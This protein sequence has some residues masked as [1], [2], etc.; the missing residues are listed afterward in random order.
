VGV[1]V[2]DCAEASGA[3]SR[4]AIIAARVGSKRTFAYPGGVPPELG[5]WPGGATP[6]LFGSLPPGLPPLDGV[7]VLGVEGCDEGGVAVP[8]L[9]GADGVTGVPEL[10]VPPPEPPM[11]E[12]PEPLFPFLFFFL[13]PGCTGWPVVT[14]GTTGCTVGL[15]PVPPPPPPLDA[16]AI[17]TIRKNTITTAATSRRRR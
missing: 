10:G 4:S 7:P 9:E 1:G 6:P 3:A 15:A 11:G 5:P 8:P 2:P 14:G 13:S 12:P 16:T 17:T